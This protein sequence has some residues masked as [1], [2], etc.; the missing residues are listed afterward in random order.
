M[1]E[2]NAAE[3]REYAGKNGLSQ[4]DSLA[5]IDAMEKAQGEANEAWAGIRVRDETINVTVKKRT[6]ERD[7]ARSLLRDALPRVKLRPL[8]QSADRQ[9]EQEDLLARIAKEL[10]Q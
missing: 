2:F 8:G 5:L 9:L 4:E 7:S 1:S 6:A 3:W 10:G